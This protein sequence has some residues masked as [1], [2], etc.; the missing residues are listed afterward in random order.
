[1]NS[2]RTGCSKISCGTLCE[3]CVNSSYCSECKSGNETNITLDT[4][5][6]ECIDWNDIADIDCSSLERFDLESNT[7]NLSNLTMEDILCYS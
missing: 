5:S 2:S 1:M 3:L 4:E 6:G 7:Q